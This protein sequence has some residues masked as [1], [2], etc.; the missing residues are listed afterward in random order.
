MKAATLPPLDQNRINM[1]HIHQYRKMGE[2][3]EKNQNLGKYL[4]IFL[5]VSCNNL[6]QL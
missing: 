3:S 5:N 4:L 6:G 2:Y 1:T